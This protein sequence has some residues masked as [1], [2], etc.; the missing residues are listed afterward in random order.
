MPINAL[1]V[2]KLLSCRQPG[3]NPSPNI[4]PLS[5]NFPANEVFGNY[6]RSGK[7][8]PRTFQKPDFRAQRHNFRIDRVSPA[9][10]PIGASG[11][12]GAVTQWLG[13][14]ATNEKDRQLPDCLRPRRGMRQSTVRRTGDI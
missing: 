4:H 6:N 12:S 3:S 5:S 1:L 13:D 9:T 2:T 14:F 8:I 10:Q 7:P 11:E